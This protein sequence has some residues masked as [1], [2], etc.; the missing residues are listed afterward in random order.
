MTEEEPEVESV[1]YVGFWARSLAFVFDN[2]I[3]FVITIPLMAYISID[4]DKLTDVNYVEELRFKLYM[5]LLVTALV[6][7][8]CWKYLAATPGK[9]LLKSYIVNASI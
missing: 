2:I 7:I 6:I 9:L 1:H 3:G 8:G 4:L 5:A